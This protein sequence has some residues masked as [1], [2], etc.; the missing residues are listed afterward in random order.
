MQN[1]SS[2]S[3]H[4]IKQNKNKMFSKDPVCYIPRKVPLLP[5]IPK[6]TTSNVVTT[7]SDREGSASGVGVWIGVALGLIVV[8]GLLI[9][10]IYFYR[11]AEKYRPS[12]EKHSQS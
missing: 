10:G 6:R 7:T 12:L 4:P 2:I 3:P 5:S 9:V 1:I 11:Q 8:I